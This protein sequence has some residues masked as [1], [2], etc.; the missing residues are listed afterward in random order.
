MIFMPFGSFMMTLGGSLGQLIMPAIA[1]VALILKNRDNFGGSLGL[2]WVGQSLMDLAPYINDARE[3][4]LMLLGGG[5]GQDRPGIHDWENILLD[6][7]LIG[8]DHE[9]AAGADALGTIL[10]L[11]ALL[12]GGY[13]LYCQYQN[14]PD[15][16]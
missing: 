11:L 16:A 6:L 7:R 5:I 8:H 3:L 15:D 1:M 12:W 4:K 9:I 2:W 13:V 14:L 10:L